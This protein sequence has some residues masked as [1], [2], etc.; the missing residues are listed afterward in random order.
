MKS[1]KSI[2][3]SSLSSLSKVTNTKKRIVINESQKNKIKKRIAQ[4]FS[5][6]MIEQEMKLEKGVAKRYF[7]A[8]YFR[9]SNIKTCGLCGSKLTGLSR[10]AIHCLSCQ[11][12]ASDDD[13]DFYSS[14][15]GSPSEL[16]GFK[17][18]EKTYG[19]LQQKLE[20]QKK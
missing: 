16:P 19:R 8:I 13:I 1:L 6:E 14:E 18:S 20:E 12:S 11:R 9:P 4:G 15:V 5:A 3:L 17:V 2:S 7:K 10:H